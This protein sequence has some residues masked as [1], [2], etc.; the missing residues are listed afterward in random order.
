M[1]NLNRLRITKPTK[2][3]CHSWSKVPACI[4]CRRTFHVL[5]ANLIAF[6]LFISGCISYTNTTVYQPNPQVRPRM[7]V[8]DAKQAIKESLEKAR[9]A[10]CNFTCQDVKVTTTGFSFLDK[11]D[12]Y[13][14]PQV[15]SY[16]F[17]KLPDLAVIQT[18]AWSGEYLVSVG[19]TIVNKE[20]P[21]GYYLYWRALTAATNFVEAI[22]AIRYGSSKGLLTDD[23]VAFAEFKKQAKVWHSSPVKPPLPDQVQRFRV[24]AEDA[25]RNKDLEKAADCYEKGLDIYPLWP[26]GQFNAAL[27][28]GEVGMYA[29]AITHMKRYLELSP[30]AKDAKAAQEK[31]YVWEEKVK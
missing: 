31:I 24:L 13:R 3:T 28:C 26:E 5:E 6:V 14:Q 19:D 21:W 2:Q 16:Q 15:R 25:V 22:K 30:D 17:G 27:I 23:E 7:T 9:P 1:Q 29:K 18:G 8:S 11:G 12:N 20:N 10:Y 4:L